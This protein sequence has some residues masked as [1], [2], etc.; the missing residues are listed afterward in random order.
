L[1]FYPPGKHLQV[2]FDQAAD[3]L[4][5]AKKMI[6]EGKTLEAQ[7]EIGRY[8]HVMVNARPYDQINN[9]VFMNQTN[10]LLKL[11]GHPGISQGE[12]DHLFMRLNSKQVDQIWP[13]VLEGKVPSASGYGLKPKPKKSVGD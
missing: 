9:S 3:H 1:H 2:Y 13:Q 7:K 11:T 4:F 6:S 8:Y 5:Q 12:L 10:Y